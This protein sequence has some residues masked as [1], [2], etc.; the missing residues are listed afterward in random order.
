[1]FAGALQETSFKSWV[2]D[3]HSS[4]KWLVKKWGDVYL[5]ETVIAHIR[6]L[7]EEDFAC[8][9]LYETPAQFR[10]WFQKVEGYMNSPAFAAEGGR[11]LSGLAKDLRLRCARVIKLKGERIPK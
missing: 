4:T 7:S 9:R 6:R 5:H 10:Q 11:G 1:M 8:Q 3:N 2:G